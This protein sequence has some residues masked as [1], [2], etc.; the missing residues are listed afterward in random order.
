MAVSIYQV[1]R[2]LLGQRT[3]FSI[4]TQIAYFLG[5]PVQG[6]L[7]P[8]LSEE[9]MKKNQDARCPKGD[10]PEDWE[11]YDEGMLPVVGR[12]AY[13]IYHGNA[14]KDGRPEKVTERLLCRHAGIS[15]HRLENMPRC[16]G[17]GK[18]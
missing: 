18:I 3:D 17:S 12:T 5:I 15:P 16:R 6:L 1:Q 2:T 9:Q 8:A 11:S 4:V 10:I 7:H 13:D 14:N